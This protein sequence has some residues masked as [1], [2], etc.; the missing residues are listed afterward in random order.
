MRNRQLA[1]S[2][3][4]VLQDFSFDTFF[5]WSSD[6]QGQCGCVDSRGM[7]EVRHSSETRI[8]NPVPHVPYPE[9]RTSLDAGKE[10]CDIEFTSKATI[11]LTATS[12]GIKAP[13]PVPR[14]PN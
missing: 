6:F 4:S 2:F 12:D 7:R 11:G 9:S 1:R 10:T 13:H 5:I 8:P 3:A 14:I